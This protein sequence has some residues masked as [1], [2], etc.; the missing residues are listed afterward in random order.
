MNAGDSVRLS[1]RLS[2]LGAPASTGRHLREAIEAD[3]VF[4]D[5]HCGGARGLTRTRIRWLQV[6]IAGPSRI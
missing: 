2:R 5:R 6:F 3:Q 1:G 4:V